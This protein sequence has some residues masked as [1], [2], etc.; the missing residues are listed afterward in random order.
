MVTWDMVV[1]LSE[2]EPAFS[3]MMV[4]GLGLHRIAVS[5]LEYSDPRHPETGGYPMCEF[6]D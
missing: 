6:V 2:V 4:P 3:G 1:S 5:N